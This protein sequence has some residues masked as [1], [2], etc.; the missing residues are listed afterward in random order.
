MDKMKMRLAALGKSKEGGF[1]KDQIQKV[2][3]RKASAGMDMMLSQMMGEHGEEEMGEDSQSMEEEL[4][5]LS[6]EEKKLI[7]A[8]RKKKGEMA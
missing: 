3:Q 4:G 8:Y 1:G 5:E 2:R 7:M 6:P